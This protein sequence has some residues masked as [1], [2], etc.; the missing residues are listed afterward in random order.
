MLAIIF[1][2]LDGL[3]DHIDRNLSPGNN[4]QNSIL[5]RLYSSVEVLKQ[6]PKPNQNLQSKGYKFSVLVHSI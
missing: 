6:Q 4:I 1:Q 2:G 5:P 3:A